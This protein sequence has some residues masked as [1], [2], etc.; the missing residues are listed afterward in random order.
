MSYANGLV[1]ELWFP[2]CGDGGKE[3]IEIDVPIVFCPG[4]NKC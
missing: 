2:S 4:E 1:Q 3:T